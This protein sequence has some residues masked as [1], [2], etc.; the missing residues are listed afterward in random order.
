MIEKE[1]EEEELMPGA[2]SEDELLA[3]SQE[4]LA[5]ESSTLGASRSIA[6]LKKLV[7][8]SLESTAVKLGI[9]S[10][11][12]SP[13]NSKHSTT[14]DPSKVKADARN[15]TKKRRSTGVLLKSLYQKAMHILSKIARNK[16]AGT[17]NERDEKDFAK[18]QAIVEEYNSKRLA[19]EQ[20]AKPIALK[21]HRS[22]E[23]VE[24]DH[25]RS[26]VGKRSD[27]K[28]HPKK[29]TQQQPDNWP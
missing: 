22:Q 21:R 5:V 26:R 11:R 23:E 13:P 24:Q 6:V 9:A 25:K 10:T 4:T 2:S 15:G 29:R 28:Q 17:V 12:H 19:N 27:A 20:K 16:E 14:A 18:Y 3:S 8:F 1:E 7:V